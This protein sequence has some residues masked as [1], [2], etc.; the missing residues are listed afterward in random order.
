MSIFDLDEQGRR[1]LDEQVALNPLDLSKV[2]PMFFHGFS[3]GVGQ[4]T[5]RG[6]ARAGATL[7]IVGAAP[8]MAAQELGS[9]RG[10]IAQPLVRSLPFGP[11][12][13]STFRLAS[14]AGDNLL[15]SYF[16]NT[17]TPAQQAVEYWTP[18]PA[19]IGT[20]GRVLGGLS[21]IILPLAAAGGNPSLLI[22]TEGLQTPATL[23]EQGVDPA[24]ATALGTTAAAATALG[25][26]IPAAFG[27]NLVQRVVTGAAAN[28]VVGTA[29]QGA[30]AWVLGAAGYDDLS[31]QYSPWNVEAR[32]VD[33]L[34]GAAF[35]GIAHLQARPVSVAERD[36][37]LAAA[38]A[39]HLQLD[40]AP[41]VPADQVS[42]AAHQ[43]AV[44]DAISSLLRGEQVSVADLIDPA[45]F[46]PRQRQGIAPEALEMGGEAP[47]GYTSYRR[48]LES[49][50]RANAGNSAS[51]ALGI[52]QFT[53]PTWRR[54]VAQ[55]KPAWAEGLSDA[56]LLA[57]RRDPAK[58]GEM[59]QALDAQSAAN[60][61]QEGLPATAHN[62][63][64]L[65]HF[66]PASGKR[67]ARAAEGAPISDL[68]T[69]EQ[70]AANPYLQGMTKGEALANWDA[71]ARR[72]GVL[73]D[74]GLVDTNEAGQALRRRLVDE[75]DAL[76]DAYSKLEDSAGG[77]VLNTD[78]ARELAPEYLADRTRSADVHEAAS[79]FV[80]MLYERKLAAPTP[81]GFDRTVLF[82]AGGTGAG[83]T[84]ALAA[85]GEG[86]GHP[87][88]VYDT[89]MNTLPS[90]ISKIEQ[91]LAAGR[92]VDIAYIY[93]DPVEALTGGA[94]PRAQRQAERFGTGR[95]V[96]LE[97]HARTH[98]GVRPTM[99]A[100]AERY[101][102]NPHVNIT[103]IDNSR[104]RGKQKV[105]DLASL[106]RVEE[107]SLRERLRAA[108]E[109]AHSTGL[110]DDLYRGFGSAGRRAPGALD[111]NL[112][113]NGSQEAR[114]Q[115]PGR[116][117][118]TPDESP[119]A[120]SPEAQIAAITDQ[121][122]AEAVLAFPDLQ[123]T[124]DD[125]SIVSAAD[126]LAQAD[127]DIV[128]AQSDSRGFAAAV[129][130]SLRFV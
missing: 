110:A 31:T 34:T 107:D 90:A 124:L 23:V 52:D 69:P 60:L 15:D 43:K 66:G 27:S 3:R 81:E 120:A 80:K 103:A 128:R 46:L 39:K 11:A 123:V 114:A 102:D 78:T 87:E 50:G 88:I 59:A 86:A 20:A 44:T 62:L 104:G 121:A 68:I 105:V 125:G 115:G 126:A 61:A 67:F 92:D 89:N 85:R 73:P 70:L 108:L 75:P 7:A 58:S 129:A 18:D 76:V 8:V 101:A 40:T 130:C 24:T 72:A 49:G 13:D 64:A 118:S 109:E 83:K 111:G 95:T 79:D 99:E 74:G 22:G 2:T 84:T 112:G 117:V 33:L 94:I 77:T 55:T 16:D 35:G 53:A 82:T 17:V 65:H 63:Y 122:A 30:Q 28:T 113:R 4:G 71:R 21:E 100:L 48:A 42:S 106:P 32:A 1:T 41:G 93:R 6:G 19:Q 10:R 29:S 5:L 37:V 45:E 57:A 98:A 26:K 12:L 47:S 25:F 56:Q 91:A 9:E 127:A 51:S 97:E 54:I 116:Q 38:N 96:P 36:A 119:A 14:A